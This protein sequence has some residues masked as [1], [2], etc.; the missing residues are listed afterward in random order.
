MKPNVVPIFKGL[1][2]QAATTEIDF[3][4]AAKRR[5]ADLEAIVSFVLKVGVKP[6]P[7]YDVSEPPVLMSILR[8]SLFVSNW[9]GAVMNRNRGVALPFRY[10]VKDRDLWSEI[11]AFRDDMGG[12]SRIVLLYEL[13]PPTRLDL[14]STGHADKLPDAFG[15]VFGDAHFAEQFRRRFGRPMKRHRQRPITIS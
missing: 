4:A 8:D 13:M 7:H 15:E 3:S 1:N 9:V 10:V 2:V 11:E 14:S 6:S 5:L 12:E